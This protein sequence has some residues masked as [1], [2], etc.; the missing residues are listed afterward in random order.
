MKWKEVYILG[1]H[2]HLT[3]N[4]ECNIV[5]LNR[6][7]GIRSWLET[8]AI[9]IRH[10]NNIA[11]IFSRPFY[12]RKQWYNDRMRMDWILMIWHPPFYPYHDFGHCA[13]DSGRTCVLFS[14]Q[15]AWSTLVVYSAAIMHKW[16]GTDSWLLKSNISTRYSWQ[17]ISIATNKG[18]WIKWNG[19]IEFIKQWNRAYVLSIHLQR[20][21]I[22]DSI[23]ATCAWTHFSL[24]PL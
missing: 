15:E 22:H 16:I 12:L 9:Q 20:I 23:H 5:I 14:S 4:N 17:S 3:L 11:N 10:Y 21:Q 8:V 7:G 24:I 18:E 6:Q 2:L 1:F 13:N 19:I